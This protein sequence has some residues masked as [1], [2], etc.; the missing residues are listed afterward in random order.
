MIPRND[1]VR[2]DRPCLRTDITVIRFLDTLL[3]CISFVLCDFGGADV[4][5]TFANILLYL[6]LQQAVW[7]VVRFL[8]TLLLCISFV[9]CDFGGTDVV[10]TFANILLYLCV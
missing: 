3:L 6:L 4:V 7:L 2:T 9:L 1:P 5:F 8:D 10:F